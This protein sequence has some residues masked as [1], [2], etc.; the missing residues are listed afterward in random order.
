MRAF[1]QVLQ[2]HRSS[3]RSNRAATAQQVNDEKN[4]RDQQQQMNQTSG[5]VE[6][7]SQEPENQKNRHNPPN[8]SHYHSSEANLRTTLAQH[9]R[10]LGD[11]TRNRPSRQ[12]DVMCS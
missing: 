12:S 9:K 8:Q 2:A 4:E 11:L 7:D 1:V 5:H 3:N 10:I 6:T